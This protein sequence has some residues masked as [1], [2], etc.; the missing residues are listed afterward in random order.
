MHSTV[1]KTYLQ[2][3]M[4]YMHNMKEILIQF[5]QYNHIKLRN[6]GSEDHVGKSN[7]HN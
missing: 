3:L 6:R 2:S 5:V 4:V 7:I 1:T